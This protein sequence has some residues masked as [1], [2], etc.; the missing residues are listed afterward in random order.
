MMTLQWGCEKKDIYGQ[1]DKCARAPACDDG[2]RD[3][4]GTA[5][6]LLG[7]NKDVARTRVNGSVKCKRS[8]KCIK[9]GQ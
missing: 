5:K 3:A 7:A 1:A 8:K 4:A 9:H 2:A 6:S